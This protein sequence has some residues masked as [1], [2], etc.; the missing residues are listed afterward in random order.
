MNVAQNSHNFR[1]RLV[2]EVLQNS[3]KFRAGTR[4]LYAYPG[5]RGTGVQNVLTEISGTGMYRIRRSSGYGQYPAKNPPQGAK[6]Q[7]I[8][9]E[10]NTHI[11]AFRTL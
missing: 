5:Y 8:D 2:V 3:Q 7:Q 6:N 9:V 4:M 10:T 11:S 1:V